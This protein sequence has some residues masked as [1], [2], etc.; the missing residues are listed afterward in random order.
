MIKRLFFICLVVLPNIIFGQLDDFTLDVISANETCLGNGTLTFATTGTTPGSTVTFY[1]YQLP[2][3]TTPIAVQT[4]NFLA[5]QTSGTYLVNAVQVLGTKQN[6]QSTTAIIS[7][8]IVPLDYFITSTNATCNDGTLTVNV[9]S[10]IGDQYEIIAGPVTRPLQPSPLFTMLPGGLYTVRVFDNCGDANVIAHTVSSGNATIT[11][12]PG[13]FAPVLP[14]CNMLSVYH[15]LTAMP[16]QSLQYPLQITFTVHAPNGTSQIITNT[17]TSGLS[18]D[19]E[20]LAQIP[21]FYDQPYSYD[22]MVSDSCGNTFTLNNNVVDLKFSVSLANMIATCGQYYLTIEAFIYMPNLQVTFT[23][24]PAG[25]NPNT[26]NTQ[27]PGPFAGTPIDY[28]N[29]NT[30]VPFGHYAISVSDGCGRTAIADVTLIE[31]PADPQHSAQPWPGCQSNFSDVTITIPP[32]LIVSA[33]ITAAPAAYGPTPD[34][35]SDHVTSNGRLILLGLIT[36]NYTVTLTDDCGNS[37][38]YNFIIQDVTTLLSAAARPVC[39]LGKGSVWIS[40]GSTLLTAVQMTAAPPAYGHTLP[41][42]VSSYI[43]SDGSFSMT[44]LPPGTYSFTALNNCGITKTTTILVIGYQVTATDFTLLPHCGSFDFSLFH[45]TNSVINVYWLQKFNPITNTWGNPVDGTPYINGTNPNALNSYSIQNNTT[46]L[47]L[48]FSGV[49]RIIKSF[50]GFNDG[51]ISVSRI[52]IEVIKEFEFD[53]RIQFTGI[54]KINCDGTQIDVK[55]YAIGAPP[56]MYSIIEK[57]GLPFFVNNGTNNIFLNLDPAI[58]T[59]RVGQ[60]CGDFRNYISDVTQLPSLAI[61]QQPNDMAACDDASSDGTENFILTNQNAAVLGSLNA[62][63]YTITYHLL[64]NDAV[65]GSNPL[66]SVYNSGNQLIFCRLKFNNNATDC[67]DIVSFNLIVRPYL[68]NQYTITMCENQTATLNPGNGF[69]SYQWSTGQASQSIV[70]NQ[71]GQY[72]VDVVKPYPTGNCTGKFTYNVVTSVAPEID[73]LNTV[74]WSY[75]QNSIEVVLTNNSTGNYEYSLDN[76]TFQDSPIFT[77]LV[78]GFYTVY[79]RDSVCDGDSSNALLLYYPKFF[80]PNGDG[81]N[82]FWKVRY[83]DFEPGMITYIYDRYGKL[84]TN[85]TPES[86]GW[87]GNL[88]GRQLP[89]TDYWFVVVRA[90]GRNLK[91]HFAMKR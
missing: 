73:H 50:Q 45:D 34:D 65:S 77:N 41:Y 16:N 22:F 67:Y 37:Y 71:S 51:N 7:S 32:F 15:L 84:I 2:N 29:Y 61:A 28:G 55:L 83:S 49:F 27:H 8:N 64:Y 66:P 26:F 87:D 13:G 89:S 31:E 19:Q 78:I 62:A 76:I 54:E 74:D 14:A 86:R 53:G 88:N 57:N 69:L 3:Q 63:S 35:V 56:L 10:G 25:F 79:V 85:F 18:T 33:I 59:F 21:F 90:D 5:G 75:D 81:I 9:T 44:D 42:N 17:L 11:I 80:T 12:G 47:N 82:D 38:V 58:Y 1:V 48:T 52:C 23:D 46:T 43:G 60:S 4:N 91:G 68:S 39:E 36:G 6:S 30:P 20:A 40:G 70:V 72:T 24:A